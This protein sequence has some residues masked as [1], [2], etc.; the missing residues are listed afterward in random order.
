M[1]KKF[2]LKTAIATMIGVLYGSSAGPVIDDNTIVAAHA[3]N[4]AYNITVNADGDVVIPV[5]LEG[6]E[7]IGDP[8]LAGGHNNIQAVAL[9]KDKQ[10]I[11]SYRGTSRPQDWMANLGI[12]YAQSY[13][14]TDPIVEHLLTGF[15]SALTYHGVTQT[16]ALSGVFGSDFGP[17]L[18]KFL[19]KGA[20]FAA[21]IYSAATGM[22]NGVK[23]VKDT[24]SDAIELVSNHKPA[25]S[26]GF[27]LT[28]LA[29]YTSP[30]LAGVAAA[31]TTIVG[32]A[33]PLVNSARHFS[34][35][36]AGTFKDSVVRGTNFTVASQRQLIFDISSQYS[37]PYAAYLTE[38][39]DFTRSVL[40]SS[41]FPADGAV[42]QTTGH[43]L[44]AHLGTD[45]FVMIAHGGKGGS[46]QEFSSITFARPNG[47][48][49]IYQTLLDMGVKAPHEES[50]LRAFSDSSALATVLG[51]TFVYS[52]EHDIVARIGHSSANLGSLR[53]LTTPVHDTYKAREGHKAINI[54]HSMNGIIKT[55][56]NRHHIA[57][58]DE[59]D[60]KT[61]TDEDSKLNATD[62]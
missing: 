8:H 59:S 5:G 16:E 15:N 22:S 45:S 9:K 17:I 7:V 62:K 3:A 47:F 39:K 31:G 1:R 38:V 21:P 54:H 18:G 4:F 36:V 44:G 20:S 52:H 41:E 40:N 53:F 37:H 28:G 34:R 24:A 26:G 13:L 48:G 19:S 55:L 10:V 61:N 35:T 51:Q 58:T 49:G 33:T 25:S 43:S 57:D 60:S 32:A 2:F 42:I 14:T 11:I 23:A 50:W 56:T 30:F 29:A 12:G 27:L 46:V 6:Y